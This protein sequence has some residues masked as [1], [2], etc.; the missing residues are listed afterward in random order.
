LAKA[1]RELSAVLSFLKEFSK[2]NENCGRTFFTKTLEYYLE[3]L[4]FD[5]GKVM[6]GLDEEIIA[7]NKELEK[8]NKLKLDR[9]KI[10]Q[11]F[12]LTLMNQP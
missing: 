11:E 6:N 7:S 4:K 2:K 12:H 8:I 1:A 3:A 10:L 5:S 9:I